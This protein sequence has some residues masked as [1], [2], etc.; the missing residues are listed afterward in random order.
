MHGQGTFYDPRL[1]DPVRF[2]VAARAG[3]GNVRSTPDLV[4]PKLGALH[5]YQLAIPAPAPPPGSFDAA[6]ALRGD[7]LFTGKAGCARCHVPPLYT[8]PGWN[9]HTAAEI[10]L[11]DFQARRAPDE[12]YRTAPL[13]GLWTHQRGG[14]YHDGRFGT[15]HDVVAHYDGFFG[16]NLT[17]AE[18]GDLIEFLKSL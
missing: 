10:G 17:D 18:I 1:D 12:R 5:F 4:T 2:P 8:E 13:R 16:L 9:M 15:L 14:F 6:A 3:F 11:D 7:A